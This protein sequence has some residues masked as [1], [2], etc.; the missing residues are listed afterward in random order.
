MDLTLA[1]KPKRERRG[2][3]REPHGKGERGGRKEHLKRG[4]LQRFASKLI[5]LNEEGESFMQKLHRLVEEAGAKST[6]LLGFTIEA[7]NPYWLLT[8]VRPL[9]GV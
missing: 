8:A 9:S 5:H 3:G 7:W 6:R 4:Q 1:T 2:R